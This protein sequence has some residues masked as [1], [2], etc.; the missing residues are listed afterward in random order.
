MINAV[1]AN[2]WSHIVKAI[3][4]SSNLLKTTLAGDA[5]AV[6]NGIED[7]HNENISILSYNDE[8]SLSCVLTLAY[9]A[10]RKDYV[11]HRELPTGKGFADVVLMP[12]HNVSLPAII[13]ELKY[14][15]SP[16]AAIAQIK[17]KEY[18]RKIC[19]DVKDV[20]LVGINYDKKTKKHKCIIE[21][22]P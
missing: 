18:T 19:E 7:V 5:D 4:Q 22:W 16:E 14:D 3:E 12:R 11:I 10:A 17:D 13:F 1:K 9:I 15:D 6:A 8:N 20:L 2:N 21:R